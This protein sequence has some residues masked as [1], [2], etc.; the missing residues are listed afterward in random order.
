MAKVRFG[1]IGCGLVSH[2]HGKAIAAAENAVLVA[3]SDVV[4]Q[5]AEEFARTY[6][7]GAVEV[8]EL[9]GR[10]DVDVISVLTPNHLHHEYAVRAARAGKHVL[11]EKPPDVS[12]SKVDMMIEECRRM[13]VKLG[14]VLQCRF[15]RAVEA[16][17]EA[18]VQGRFG[19]LLEGDVYM[20]WYRP[21]DYYLGWRRE[22]RYGSGTTIQQAFHYIDLLYYILG[23]VRRVR[24]RMTNFCHPEAD[25][26]DTVLATLEYES[27]AQG[28]VLAS[29]AFYPGTDIRLEINGER[30]TAVMEGERIRVWKFQDERPE[31]EEIR[32][33]GSES[34]MTGATGAADL[35]YQEHQLLIED[36]AEAVASG[37]EPKVTGMDA[38][39]AL[40]I[41]L[42]MYRSADTGEEVE[43]PIE[44]YEL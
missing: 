15:R 44:D 11:V 38:R 16:I 18:V 13:G 29:T 34:A 5:R 22:R 20:K 33:I 4:R 3:C 37:R 40:E 27:G 7:C 25:L 2:F 6:G 12:L 39:P 21:R 10:E 1:I 19:R 24:A 32:N 14:V 31:D 9:L 28:V 41:A 43:L 23:P 36:M 26:E 8:E 42:A 35:G 30:G 17:K